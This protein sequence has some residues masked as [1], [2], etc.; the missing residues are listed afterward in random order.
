MNKTEQNTPDLPAVGIP[1]DWRARYWW[2]KA[3]RSVIDI[4]A[5]YVAWSI[6]FA[7]SGS[8]VAAAITAVAVCL[9]GVWCFY[10]GSI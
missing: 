5:L 8:Y 3:L 6:Q 4:F 1:V 7:A 2:W 9:Y 10:D